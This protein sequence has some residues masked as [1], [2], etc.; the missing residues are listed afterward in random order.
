MIY[1]GN[2]SKKCTDIDGRMSIASVLGPVGAFL[3]SGWIRGGGVCGGWKRLE[4]FL[5]G[6]LA[7]REH[8]RAAGSTAIWSGALKNTCGR[9]AASRRIVAPTCSRP[10][11]G[12][13]AHIAHRAGCP[14]D[15]R[16]GQRRYKIQLLHHQR[17]RRALGD[18]AR[19]RGDSDRVRS[20]RRWRL[21]IDR[22]RVPL[23]HIGLRNR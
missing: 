9:E 22:S 20:C 1:E 11:S 13:P 10:F 14:P 16:R 21:N 15:S 3:R 18:R 2:R 19:R 12:G 23:G 5:R 17:R 4:A 6:R 8:D 7:R